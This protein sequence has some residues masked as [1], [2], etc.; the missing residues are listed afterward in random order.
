MRRQCALLGVCAACC[1]AT[2]MGEVPPPQSPTPVVAVATPGQTP[3][4][5]QQLAEKIAQRDQ[6]QREIEAISRAL[7]TGEQVLLRLEVLE[8]DVTRMRRMGVTLAL[9]SGSEI[10]TEK[11]GDVLQLIAD[12]RRKNLAKVVMNPTMVTV[13]GRPAS[14]L[15]GDEIVV[16][17]AS[18]A[19][20]LREFGTRVEVTPL[21]QKDGQLQLE[22]RP[23]V[24]RRGAASD[25]TAS[26]GRKVPLAEV[27]ESRTVCN[28]RF[29]AA[30]VVV[31]P[32]EQRTMMKRGALGR[33]T[34]TFDI[35]TV[36]IATPER[37]SPAGEMIAPAAYA[38]PTLA[39]PLSP[40]R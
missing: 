6:L 22:V 29:G 10:A 33:V 9:E 12:L 20:E 7:S 39:E 40:G 31:G 30:T 25:A 1:V 13:S 38:A 34:E 21:I 2:A 26:D 18:G 11:G 37:T 19:S 23:K 28:L 14:I 17:T 24:S 27:R 15:A 8:V 16:T 36:V 4:L 32:I 5:Q 3:T 35:A